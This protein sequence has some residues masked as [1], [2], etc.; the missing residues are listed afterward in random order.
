M[1]R[2]LAFLLII[3]AITISVTA[4]ADIDYSDIMFHTGHYF[5][6]GEPSTWK[7]KDPEYVDGPTSMRI[8]YDKKGKG[9]N[10][11]QYIEM[12]ASD[13]NSSRIFDAVMQMELDSRGLTDGYYYEDSTVNN[14]PVRYLRFD[15][16][17]G[18]RYC[19]CIIVHQ[20]K[21]ITIVYGDD[22]SNSDA[23]FN[24]MYLATTVKAK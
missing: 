16:Q 14:Y 8:I 9:S 24:I 17:N 11:I 6:Y 7:E 3:V 23:W 4:F 1:K 19:E 12:E 15:D 21:V 2:T 10:F 20:K 22:V 5:R 13:N 18:L